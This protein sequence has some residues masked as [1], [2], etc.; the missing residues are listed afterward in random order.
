MK[1]PNILSNLN[2]W[3]IIL[4][5]LG[6]LVL[7]LKN[8]LVGE[9][10]KIY[11]NPWYKRYWWMGWRPFYK[12]SPP[13]EKVERKIKL[14]RRVIVYGFIPPRYQLEI[15]GFLLI[16]IGAIFQIIE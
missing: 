10:N 4:V 14:T 3:G 16:L 6:A 11:T 1:M 13:L 9:H 8:T 15:L 12:I 7:L 5:V 2:F